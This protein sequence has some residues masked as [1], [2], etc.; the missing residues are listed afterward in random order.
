MSDSKFLGTRLIRWGIGVALLASV[1]HLGWEA[2]H[3]GVRAHHL[4]ARND[5]PSVS[6]WWGLLVLPLLGGL[7]GVSVQGRLQRNRVALHTSSIALIG[8][9]LVGVTMST[10]FATGY[11]DVVPRIFLGVLA[12]GVVLP[13]YRPEYLF[14]FLLGTMF[15]F[16]PVIPLA[17]CLF[18][19]VV[20]FT[21][22][23]LIDLIRGVSAGLMRRKSA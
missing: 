12:T 13:I 17:G 1:I 6:N 10:L 16:G 15:V 14:G 19:A 4:L 22:H 3:G 7:T 9:A 20:S 23:I 18:A 8:S 5:L 21:A 2:T 11:Q